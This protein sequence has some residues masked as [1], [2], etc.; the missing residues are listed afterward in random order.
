MQR[1]IRQKFSNHTIISV[2]H[3]LD[4]ILDFDKVIVLDTG[5]VVEVD[6][7]YM[8]L[9]NPDSAF[10]KLYNSTAQEELE[11]LMDAK[12]TA[13]TDSSGPS[14]TNLSSSSSA[15]GTDSTALGKSSV[16]R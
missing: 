16:S 3:K 9:S 2:A 8:L 12:I 15:R 11:E 13:S 7:P 1:L 5:K 6:D 4:T 10:A 14:S